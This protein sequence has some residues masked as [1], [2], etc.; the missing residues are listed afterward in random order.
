[1]NVKVDNLIVGL[2]MDG[3]V[4]DSTENKIRFAKKFGF[5]LKPEETPAAVLD[6]LVPADILPE[7]QQLLYHR[8]ETALTASVMSG[9]DEGLERLK[10]S[11]TPYFLISRRKDPEIARE[12]LKRR[13]LWPRYFN[14]QNAFFVVTPED[15]N[16]KATELGVNI[17]LDDEPHVLEKLSF[18]KRRF[19]FDRFGLFADFPF[20][21]KK[22]G[23]W[24]EFLRFFL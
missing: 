16:V 3:V 7:I 2:D 9:A 5:D 17:Y 19:L 14:E 20:V 8:P 11:G 21:H 12:L 18:V 1:M 13:G 24:E 10:S 6:N 15:K 4:I 22:V 23:S